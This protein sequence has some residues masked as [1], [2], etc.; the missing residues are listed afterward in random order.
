MLVFGAVI[1]F[2][3]LLEREKQKAYIPVY[4]ASLTGF[5]FTGL[6]TLLLIFLAPT[7]VQVGMYFFELLLFIAL[8]AMYVNYLFVKKEQI[9]LPLF[10][11]GLDHISN[12]Y[13]RLGTTL[14]VILIAGFYIG[15]AL[16]I[17]GTQKMNCII[18]AISVIYIV[19]E[20]TLAEKVKP[21]T[22]SMSIVGYSLQ[23]IYLLDLIFIQLSGVSFVVKGIVFF[24]IG[25]Y[26]LYTALKRK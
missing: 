18:I 2:V 11:K 3:S 21:L 5:G 23:A 16:G 24:V 25:A 20:L 19:T 8:I 12:Y 9:H 17:A 26:G 22:K 1:L 14:F 10:R 6:L 13:I 7:E 4:I 15:Y